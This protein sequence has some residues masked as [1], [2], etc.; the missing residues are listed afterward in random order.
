MKLNNCIILKRN[1]YTLRG[2]I[3]FHGSHRNGLRCVVGHYTANDYRLNGK[4]ELY[5][6]RKI[7]IHNIKKIVYYVN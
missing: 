1:I 2:I 3:N 5:D 4:W 6:D 7:K